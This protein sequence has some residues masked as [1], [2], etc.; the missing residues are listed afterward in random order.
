MEFVP[1]GKELSHFP[2]LKKAQDPI[3][4]RFT[5]LGTLLGTPKGEALISQAVTRV[6]EAVNPKKTR[7]RKWSVPLKTRSPHMHS[8]GLLSPASTINNLL[9]GLPVTKP[10]VPIIFL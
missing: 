3:R 10:N 5:S 9:T 7:Y 6:R 1:S 2:F 4:S 8:R